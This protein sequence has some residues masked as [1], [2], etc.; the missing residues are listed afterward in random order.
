MRIEVTAQR[1]SR[2]LL[3]KRRFFFSVPEAWSE[4][5]HKRRVQWWTWANTLTPEV[6]RGKMALSCAPWYLRFLLPEDEVAQIATALWWAVPDI[7]EM[8]VVFPDVRHKFRR[9]RCATEK[10]ENMSC[11]EFAVCDDLYATYIETLDPDK[12]Y[13]LAHILYR[14]IDR[15]KAAALARG[16][17][18]IL[19][20]G[21]DEAKDRLEKFGPLPDYI[22][23]HA[24]IYF[25]SVKKFVHKTYGSW[26]FQPEGQETESGPNYG[27][28]GIFQA[29]AESSAFG[30]IEKVHQASIHE[31]CVFLVRK[32]HEAQQ[33]EK[34][35]PKTNNDDLH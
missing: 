16:D 6:A 15:N 20:R 2:R 27:W 24:L 7:E 8:P 23:S 4:L 11:L 13:L 35:T 21:L 5:P 12:A 28:W 26:I 18:R 17:A 25:A 14:T 34:R 10:G 9:F 19:F 3:W 33:L 22:V 29:V 32:R 1:R 31:V 30:D